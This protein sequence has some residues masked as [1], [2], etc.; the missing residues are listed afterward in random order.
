MCGNHGSDNFTS[1][2]SIHKRKGGIMKQKVAKEVQ[3]IFRNITVN[4]VG[5]S[6]PI[7]IYEKRVSEKLRDNVLKMKKELGK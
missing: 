5:R 4:S 7:G 6:A 3:K 2:I 1:L